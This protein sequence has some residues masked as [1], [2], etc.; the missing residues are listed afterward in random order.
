MSDLFWLTQSQLERI[1]PHFPLSHGVPRV[2][3]LRVIS[4]IRLFDIDGERTLIGVLGQKMVAHEAPSQ[5]RIEAAAADVV[6]RCGFL[7]LDNVRPQQGQL[8]GAEWPGEYVGQ[9]NDGGALEWLHG[10]RVPRV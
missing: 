2:D 3:D 7:D 10:W 1:E 4:G 9:I 6:P 8:V 5:F